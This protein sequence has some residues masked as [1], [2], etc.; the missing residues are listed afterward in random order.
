M[1][2]AMPIVRVMKMTVDQVVHMISVGH[3]LVAALRAVNVTGFV[4]THGLSA[5][6]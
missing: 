4:A 6:A 2:I 3:G 1:V 5:A